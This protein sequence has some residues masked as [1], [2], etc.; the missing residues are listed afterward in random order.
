MFNTQAIQIY[1][2][3]QGKLLQSHITMFKHSLDKMNAL[4]KEQRTVFSSKTA[5]SRFKWI[6]RA[7]ISP[8]KDAVEVNSFGANTE[9]E[10]TSSN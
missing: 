7:D 2:N 9:T 10:R 4:K 1:F 3:M 5:G 6:L 8:C